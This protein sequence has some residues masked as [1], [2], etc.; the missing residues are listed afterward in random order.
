MSAVGTYFSFQRRRSEANFPRP[1]MQAAFSRWQPSL[2][3]RITA[4]SL[5]LCVLFV[6][7]P[8]QAQKSKLKMQAALVHSIFLPGTAI[9]PDRRTPPVVS[10]KAMPGGCRPDMAFAVPVRYG[11]PYALNDGFFQAGGNR[12]K[13]YRKLNSSHR[14]R[15][16]GQLAGYNHQIAFGQIEV[17]LLVNSSE[18]LQ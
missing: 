4:Y 16:P 17:L 1:L 11:Q 10:K 14:M 6:T 9:P 5:H 13:R 18:G 2:L 3:R 12:R 8:H 7:I 15:E